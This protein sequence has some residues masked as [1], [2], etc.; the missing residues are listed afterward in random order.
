L[1]NRK[2]TFAKYLARDMRLGSKEVRVGYRQ[3]GGR[4]F[5]VEAA[6]RR[7]AAFLGSV[8]LGHAAARARLCQDKLIPASISRRSPSRPASPASSAKAADRFNTNE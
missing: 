6:R 8:Q 2:A 4:S 5:L 3:G 7:M 1:R